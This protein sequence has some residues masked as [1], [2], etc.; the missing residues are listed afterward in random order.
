MMNADS[1]PGW[2]WGDPGITITPDEGMLY[3][4][5]LMMQVAGGAS[6]EFIMGAAA[7]ILWTP[8]LSDAII[9]ASEEQIEF[10]KQFA[11]WRT[12]HEPSLKI[13]TTGSINPEAFRRIGIL[14]RYLKEQFQQV[15]SPDIL[16]GAAYAAYLPTVLPPEIPDTK[17]LKATFNIII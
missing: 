8:P 3:L 2:C 12:V 13:D 5:S 6:A 11:V 17:L 16:Q 7:M 1:R 4:K 9:S 15:D 10:V 14:D